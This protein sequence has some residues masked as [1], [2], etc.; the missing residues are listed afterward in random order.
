M[1]S[2]LQG[3]VLGFVMVL[4]GMSGGTLLVLFGIYETLIKDLVK[5]NLRPY[6]P[7][8]G[9]VLLGI[10]VSGIAFALF[11][12]AYRD[13]TVALLLGCLLA[14]I[15]A[16]LNDCPKTKKRYI[17]YTLIGLLIGFF[18]VG[19]PV[20]I[21]DAG[22]DVS[23]WILILGGALS[24]GAM[25]IPGVP[26]SSVLIVFGIYDTIIFYIKELNFKLLYFAVGNIIGIFTLVKLLETM[27]ARYKGAIS[28]FFVGLIVGSCR[29]LL[30]YKIDVSI[31]MLFAIGF[32]VVWWWSGVPL[33]TAE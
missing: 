13:P 26:G 30:P 1:G 19:E 8:M 27:Y 2:I 12:E 23:W 32:S 25:I 5:L 22:E 28:Y 3:F 6:I 21:V 29:G 11:F 20:S 14:S 4:P 9:G 10:L 24:S 18:M 7:L 15:R 16:V 31:I 33:K 17:V